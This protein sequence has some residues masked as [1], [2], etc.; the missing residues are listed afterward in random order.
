MSG[1]S[2]HKTHSPVV[3][4]SSHELTTG[5]RMSLIGS[6]W[7]WTRLHLFLSLP[8]SSSSQRLK[9]E[10]R[11]EFQSPVTAWM[12]R[13]YTVNLHGWLWIVYSLESFMSSVTASKSHLFQDDSWKH[14]VWLERW[15]VAWGIIFIH[16]PWLTTVNESCLMETQSLTLHASFHGQSLKSKICSAIGSVEGLG[17]WWAPE[18][19]GKRWH[20]FSMSRL[21]LSFFH[22]GW[23]DMEVPSESF[24]RSSCF[25]LDYI[26]SLSSIIGLWLLLS[27]FSFIRSCSLK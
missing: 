23:A 20:L 10:R 24:C 2:F 22:F 5:M 15:L 14:E 8:S 16:C 9:W 18:T 7:L 4:K 26:S 19:K 1:P 3:D 21:I 13:E 25:L 12:I 6:Q 17:F 11:V 27:V